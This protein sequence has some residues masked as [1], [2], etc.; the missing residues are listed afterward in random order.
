MITTGTLRDLLDAQR[1]IRERASDDMDAGH[2]DG[3]LYRGLAA[4]KEAIEAA[5]AAHLIAP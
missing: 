4:I 3:A 2:Y 5:Q 1:A